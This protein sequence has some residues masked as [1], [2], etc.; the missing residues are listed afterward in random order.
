MLDRKPSPIIVILVSLILALSFLTLLML[1]PGCAL[2]NSDTMTVEQRLSPYQY[3]IKDTLFRGKEVYIY[4]GEDYFKLEN[5]KRLDFAGDLSWAYYPKKV[6][7]IDSNTNNVVMTV[8]E[9]RHIRLIWQQESSLQLAQATDKPE[10]PGPQNPPQFKDILEKGGVGDKPPVDPN[11]PGI[12][13]PSPG[14]GGGDIGGIQSPGD[15][16][17]NGKKDEKVKEIQ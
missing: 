8:S 12:S 15:T 10:T 11:S 9:E 5:Q 13:S 4:I 1:V 6:I 3:L 7:V 14:I 17:S 2:R 16:G